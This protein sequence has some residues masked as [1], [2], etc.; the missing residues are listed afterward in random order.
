MPDTFHSDDQQI[1]ESRILRLP[2]VLARIGM[3][4]A[5]LYREMAAGRFVSCI[6]LGR[7]S[8]WNAALVNAWVAERLSAQTG[9]G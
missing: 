7:S 5:W 2:A 9:E 4:R 8:G 6:K 3:S 1:S